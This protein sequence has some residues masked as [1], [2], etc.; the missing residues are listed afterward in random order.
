MHTPVLLPEVLHALEPKDGGVYVD[1]TVGMGGHA[2]AILESTQP[3]GRLIGFD[4][5]AEAL[6][7][8]EERLSPY[9]HRVSLIH[10]NF[11]SLNEQ[12][13]GN[14]D[15]LLMDLGVSSYQLDTADRGFSLRQDGPLDMR[16]DLASHPSAFEVVRDLSE[17]ELA[18]IIWE[19]GEE[20]RARQVARA[21]VQARSQQPI[22]TT[23]QLAKVIQRVVPRTGH[24]QIDPAT[25]TFQALRI[26]VNRELDR[27]KEGLQHAIRALR[28]GGRLC[29]ISFHSL[30]DRIVKQTLR[31]M[32]RSCVCPPK[33]PVCRCE[34]EPQV[35]V[36][37]K[38]PL[39]AQDDELKLNP[40]ARSAKLRVAVAL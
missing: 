5:D 35:I 13:Q 7:I 2:L 18:K 15:G 1:C 22:R 29:V 36:L 39:I 32:A 24:M 19:Y 27:L 33:L 30:E 40:R 31:D 21:V 25:R 17:S 9:R 34:H 6:R 26:Y 8:A 12:F 14:A 20:R 11:A 3:S 23:I 4:C 10:A 37:T 28:P 38:R 16:M